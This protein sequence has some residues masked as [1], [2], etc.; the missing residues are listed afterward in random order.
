[1]VYF[2][3]RP[4]K[5]RGGVRKWER[6]G[7]KIHACCELGYHSGQPGFNLAHT[8][9]EFRW[10]V[11]KLEYLS[12]KFYPSLM[13]RGTWSMISLVSGDCP[14][15]GF[16]L[17][18]QVERCKKPTGIYKNV[19]S[20]PLGRAEGLYVEYQWYL[21]H[22]ASPFIVALLKALGS[23]KGSDPHSLFSPFEGVWVPPYLL[24]RLSTRIASPHAA[25]MLLH[26]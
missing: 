13:E 1:M 19:C 15:C 3:G 22:Y 9:G 16:M 17:P 14:V 23:I 7:R 5:H 11:S 10:G 4:R 20:S 8:S 21:L 18:G 25:W 12:T 26:P 6:A 2:R 24:Y